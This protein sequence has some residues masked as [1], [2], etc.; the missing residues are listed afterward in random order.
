MLFCL[1][2]FSK[3]AKENFYQE[4]LISGSQAGGRGHFV[5]LQIGNILYVAWFMF[6]F[7][8]FAMCW[9]KSVKLQGKIHRLSHLP[10]K[11]AIKAQAKWLHIFLQWLTG[12]TEATITDLFSVKKGTSFPACLR[13]LITRETAHR[14]L[15]GEHPGMFTRCAEAR[16]RFP[17]AHR[18]QGA[19]GAR[20]RGLTTSSPGAAH[21]GL[22]CAAV[23]LVIPDSWPEAS[24]PS[25]LRNLCA[26]TH[27]RC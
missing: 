6:A 24:R 11:R 26:K 17:W 22:H 18:K 16:C 1:L 2:L 8:S 14:K 9:K 7:H 20:P 27:T 25:K 10:D 23:Q 19:R 5:N 3:P 21:V 4:I 12:N 15:S 13:Y